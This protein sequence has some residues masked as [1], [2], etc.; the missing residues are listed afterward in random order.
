MAKVGL[1]FSRCLRDIADGIVDINDVLIVI[2]RTDFDPRDDESWKGIW[3]GYG[4]GEWSK[5]YSQDGGA[6]EI[7]SKYREIAIELLTSGRLHQPRQFGTY[8]TKRDEVW[9]ETVLP[10]SELDQNPAAKAAW[11]KFQLVAGLTNVELDEKYR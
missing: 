11:N 6:G 1:S 8:E 3:E 4:Y 5:A 7:N 10:S 2:A 9:L